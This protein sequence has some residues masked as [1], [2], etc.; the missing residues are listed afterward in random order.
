MKTNDLIQLLI[1]AGQYGIP[2]VIDV[3]K[4]WKKDEVTLEDIHDLLLNVKN[5]EDF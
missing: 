1:I 3:I 5:P 2:A 4:T